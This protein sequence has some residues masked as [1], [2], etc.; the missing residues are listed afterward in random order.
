MNIGK[1]L[2]V[3]DVK[4]LRLRIEMTFLQGT[5][6]AFSHSSF[7]HRGS[8]FKIVPCNAM[9]HL[10]LSVDIKASEQKTEKRLLKMG[11]PYKS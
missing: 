7:Y 11:E 2:A 5:V 9:L 4:R 6:T 3:I 1:I 10:V 8:A